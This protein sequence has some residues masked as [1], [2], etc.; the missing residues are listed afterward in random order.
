M[1]WRF[2][3]ATGH[4]KCNSPSHGTGDEMNGLIPN[5]VLERAYDAVAYVS[6]EISFSEAAAVR[7]AL[8]AA[9]LS[10]R[11]NLSPA[12]AAQMATEAAW[13]DPQRSISDDVRNRI[14][15][16]RRAQD[17]EEWGYEQDDETA[18]FLTVNHLPPHVR[19]RAAAL[20]SEGRKIHAIKFVRDETGMGLREAKDACDSLATLPP[21]LHLPIDNE[22][23][24]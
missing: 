6:A 15:A 17:R 4:V 14:D 21:V 23:P 9:M 5:G 13:D 2:D 10:V 11:M 12:E 16:A 20:M 1:V 7:R 22:P 19:D 24:F 3:S 18:R 8:Y